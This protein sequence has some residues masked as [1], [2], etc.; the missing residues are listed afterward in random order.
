MWLIGMMGSGKTT[1]GVEVAARV[2]WAF[3]DTDRMVTEMTGRSIPSIWADV[4]E[5]GFRELERRAV[6]AVPAS[7]CVAA[8]GGGSVLD[9]D[10]RE[11][12]AHGGPVVWLRCSPS[13]LAARLQPGDER[14]LLDRD[15]PT[16]DVLAEMM[17]QRSEVYASVA[18][19]IVDTDDRQVSDVVDD[20]MEIL[21]S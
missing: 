2:G 20:V 12:M 11:K 4:G 6:A 5:A 7:E 16:A 8:A 9:P 10:N 15:R 21:Q 1:V 17:G 19:H 13:K 3:Y 14:P 18:T